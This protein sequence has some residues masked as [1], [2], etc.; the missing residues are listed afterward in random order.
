MKKYQPSGAG[1]TRSPPATPAKSKMAASGPQKGRRGL[2]RGPTSL[3]QQS[4][5]EVSQLFV[6]SVFALEVSVKYLKVTFS[7]AQ[8]PVKFRSGFIYYKNVN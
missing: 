3:A 1:G 7:C 8:K 2:E 4:I 5:Y 6:G